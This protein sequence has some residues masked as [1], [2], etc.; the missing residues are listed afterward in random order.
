VENGKRLKQQIEADGL[1]A[2][3]RHVPS[4]E[5]LQVADALWAGGVKLMEVTLNSKGA[6]DTIA[7]L[8]D[9]FKGSDVVIGAGT[10]LSEEAA[11]EALDV[12]ARFLVSPHTDPR[13][14]R[15][16]LSAEAIPLP[17]VMTPT[18]V[19]RALDAGAEILKL[20]PAG[21]L[22]PEY[23]KQLRGPF[24]DTAFMAV[25][26]VDLNN[27]SAFLQAGA[28]GLGLGGCLVNVQDI[29]QGNYPALTVRAAA[30]R[31]ILEEHRPSLQ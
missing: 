23:L 30:F 7:L 28:I 10:V 11:D 13:I 31:K 6:L 15:A 25:G 20:F 2:I 17:G 4:K 14:I 3:A 24:G 18:D 29:A 19:V 26:G 5:I 12:G 22:G 8:V 9:H 16:A 1:I 27:A 21:A